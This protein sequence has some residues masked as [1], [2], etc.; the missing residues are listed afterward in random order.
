MKKKLSLTSKIFIAMGVGLSVG[1]LVRSLPAGTVK[2]TIIIGGVFKVLGQGFIS[3][4]KMLVVP[5]VFA[6]ITCGVA[7]LSNIKSL[8]RIGARTLIFY[9]STTAIAI[10]ISIGLAYLINP[11]VGLDMSSLVSEQPTIAQSSSFAD[12]LIDMIP[13]NPIKAMAE[14]NMLQVISFSII[15]GVTISILGEKV[16]LVK[17][18]MENL[19]EIFLKMVS[20]V[21]YFAPFG[22]F[23]LIATTFATTGGEAFA[24]LLKYMAVVL[25]ALLIHASVVYTGILKT[26]TNL[27]IMP[28]VKKFPK[29]GAITFS[30]ASS[31][32]AL[33]V[34]MKTMNELGVDSKVSSFT[35]P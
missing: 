19:N 17:T 28:F 34:T 35:I 30:T 15:F 13:T 7:S 12:V 3:A 16:K 10:S 22:I 5:L 2:D 1:I 6:S 4:I 14:G 27:S 26:F 31:G 29:V 9:L 24:S 23:G 25:L 11:G 21:M 32:A 20:L 33:P 18:F 8:G